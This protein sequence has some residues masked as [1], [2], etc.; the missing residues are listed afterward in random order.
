MSARPVPR[1][2][3][4]SVQRGPGHTEARAPGVPL[5]GGHASTPFRHHLPGGDAAAGRRGRGGLVPQLPGPRRALRLRSAI[6]D[7]GERNNNNNNSLAE[8]RAIRLDLQSDIHAKCVCFALLYNSKKI[9]IWRAKSTSHPCFLLCTAKV[10][11]RKETL[12]TTPRS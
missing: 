10:C 2:E 11:R 12:N 8:S 9:C 3:Q 6:A 1:G 4:L 7:P 5:S